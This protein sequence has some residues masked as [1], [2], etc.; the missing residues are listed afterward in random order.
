MSRRHTLI[1][2]KTRGLCS[3]DFFEEREKGGGGEGMRE[4]ERGDLEL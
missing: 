3:L 2:T 4:R 1:I